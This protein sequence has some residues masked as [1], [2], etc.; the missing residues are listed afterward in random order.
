MIL[1][2]CIYSFNWS[3]IASWKSFQSILTFEQDSAY[4]DFF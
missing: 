3:V 4:E 1:D 2:L